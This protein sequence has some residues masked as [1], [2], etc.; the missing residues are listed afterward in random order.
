VR[1]LAVKRDSRRAACSRSQF[2]FLVAIFVSAAH[3]RGRRLGEE[4][5]RVPEKCFGRVQSG[6][7]R[8]RASHAV[9]S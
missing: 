4:I 1:T 2:L 8:E 9:A 3:W 5:E 6:E 7:R